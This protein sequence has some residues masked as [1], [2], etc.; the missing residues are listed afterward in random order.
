VVTSSR[1]T[2]VLRVENLLN[3]ERGT[4][5]RKNDTNFDLLTLF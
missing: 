4:E 2:L 1:K 5:K 3:Q